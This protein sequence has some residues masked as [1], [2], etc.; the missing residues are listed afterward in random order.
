LK[1]FSPLVLTLFAV[2]PLSLLERIALKKAGKRYLTDPLSGGVVDGIGRIT[3]KLGPVSLFIFFSGL[4][5][6]MV[7]THA[8]FRPE[9]P[10]PG[11]A[12]E[13]LA[14]YIRNHSTYEDVYIGLDGFEI[15]LIPPQ[16]LA[17]SKKLVH[18][19]K[20]DAAL[21][22]FLSEMPS[23]ARLYSVISPSNECI[24]NIETSEINKVDNAIVTR[25]RPSMYW[26][27][28]SCIQ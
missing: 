2:M 6:C 10:R 7:L 17:I 14:R 26:M 18:A 21:R 16:K 4:L 19:I 20:T 23:R 3:R 27:L 11:V 12:G 22:R 25:V 5:V 13:A 28:Y 24:R 9:F 8:F 1:F 15:G